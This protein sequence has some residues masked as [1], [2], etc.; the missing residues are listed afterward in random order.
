MMLEGNVSDGS[1]RLQGNILRTHQQWGF[2][3]SVMN[4][5]SLSYKFDRLDVVAVADLY[6]IINYLLE[7]FFISAS[8]NSHKVIFTHTISPGGHQHLEHHRIQTV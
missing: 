6:P 1:N 5:D 3:A 4:K 2:D 7:I 8:K